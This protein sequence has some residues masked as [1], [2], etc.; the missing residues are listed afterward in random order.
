VATMYCCHR[1][2]FVSYFWVSAMGNRPG[3]SAAS[4][5]VHP[6]VRIATY[7]NLFQAITS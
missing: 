6:L 2:G 7:F 5:V 1:L 4:S 3:H